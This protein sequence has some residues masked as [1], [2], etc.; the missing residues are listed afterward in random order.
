MKIFPLSEGAF[1]ID[2]TK[3]FLPFDVN[4]DDLQQR[5]TGSL[6]VE[7]QPFLVQINSENVL[8]DTGLGYK[9][10]SGKLQI[11]ENLKK[12]GIEPS[13]ISKVLIS[14]LHIDHAGGIFTEDANGKIILNFPEAEYFIHKKEL[15]FAISKGSPSYAADSFEQFRNNPKIKILVED[16]G[17]IEPGIAYKIVGGHTPYHLAFWFREGNEIAFFG[18]DV[19]PQ[20]SQMKRNFIAKYDFDGRKSMELRSDWWKNAENEKWKMMFYHDIKNAVYQP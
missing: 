1:T 8:I 19:A 3:E 12:I 14:H 11:F 13:G 7:I 6:L 17:I 10:K 2:A 18:G 5:P 16:E 20:L 4:K 9:G 15:D